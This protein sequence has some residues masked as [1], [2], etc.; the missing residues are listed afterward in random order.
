MWHARGMNL[1][2]AI[3]V[4][5]QVILAVLVIWR[6]L[7]LIAAMIVLLSGLLC[8]FTL[9]TGCGF[10]AEAANIADKMRRADKP[11]A[12]T[13]VR[14]LGGMRAAQIAVSDA[15]PALAFAFS[16]SNTKSAYPAVTSATTWSA[17]LMPSLSLEAERDIATCFFGGSHGKHKKG[18]H[19]F[20]KEYDIAEKRQKWSF[21]AKGALHDF[22]AFVANPR[23]GMPLSLPVQGG[24]Y[25]LLCDKAGQLVMEGLK[26][27]LEIA[28][29]P[30][31][32]VVE[33][34]KG[35]VGKIVGSA[36]GVFCMPMSKS[37]AEGLADQVG[38]QAKDKCNGDMQDAPRQFQTG[39]DGTTEIMHRKYGDTN[40]A[41]VTETD[42]MKDCT[43]D[44]LKKAGKQLG[45]STTENDVDAAKCGKPAKVWMFASNGNVFMRSFSSIEQRETMSFREDRGID[46]TDGSRSG[47]VTPVVT[48]S[49]GA[50][51]EMYF[52]CQEKWSG[53]CQE[54]AMWDVRWRAR[55]RRVQPLATLASTAVEQIAVET[56]ISIASGAADLFL[57]K[58]LHDKLK[59]PKQE[60]SPE[61]KDTAVFNYGRTAGQEWNYGHSEGSPIDRVRETLAQHGSRSSIIH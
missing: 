8:A 50:H 23:L 47:N 25:S 17:S 52:D 58:L 31:G 14:I 60:L 26:K 20:N 49:I 42:W 53:P 21:S 54:E 6:I 3:N 45:D 4:I 27:M 34:A 5:M 28:H 56:L 36:P 55:L 29:L 13:V 57:D 38:S 30:G 16:G 12:Q 1:I 9:G 40:G 61:I 35:I 32:G 22:D 33:K 15:T 18:E 48:G 7:L 59:V 51:A 24:E 43:K 41:W 19:T 10:A 39:S 11:I 44:K 37:Q 46:V 2:V